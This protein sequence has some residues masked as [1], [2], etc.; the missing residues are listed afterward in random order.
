M[1]QLFIAINKDQ[2]A[3]EI[4]PPVITNDQEFHHRNANDGIAGKVEYD[5]IPMNLAS[6]APGMVE[7]LKKM[8]EAGLSYREFLPEAEKFIK[9]AEQA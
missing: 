9:I 4:D 3:L 5:Y 7:L 6:A 2:T 1:K 8:V